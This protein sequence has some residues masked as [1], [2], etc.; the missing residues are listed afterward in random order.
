M[1]KGMTYDE[2]SV[3]G[4]LWKIFRCPYQ[5]L[6]YRLGTKLTRA[7]VADKVKYLFKYYSIPSIDGQRRLA[8]VVRVTL[9]KLRYSPKDNIRFDLRQ[10]LYKV[11]QP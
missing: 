6:S 4:R 2:L 10:L 5:C 11:S 1:D 3:Y 8:Q 7:E 9:E